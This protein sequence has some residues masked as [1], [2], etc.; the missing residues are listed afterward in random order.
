MIEL[1][2]TLVVW[3]VV[4]SLMAGQPFKNWYKEKLGQR[5]YEGTSRI[6][7]NTVS[8]ITLIPVFYLLA[9]RVPSLALWS[10]P[11][12]YNYLAYTVQL[13]GLIGLAL[14]LIQ[15]D[16]WSFLGLRQFGRFL[17]GDPQPEPPARFIS[18]GTYALVRHPLYLFSLLY[19][20][21]RP[22]MTLTNLVLNIWVTIYFLIG[23]IHE[24]RRLLR[25]F[26]EDYDAYKARVPRMLPV[27]LPV[28][29]NKPG[30]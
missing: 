20:W 9:T 14:S 13:I 12:P 21:A 30:R 27:K 28:Y 29:P 5:A 7:Y 25:E 11:S 24:E 22:E 4:H 23:S 17:R 8:A 15:T 19:L 10:I 3:A 26:G 1:L 6:F 18:G 16:I 2:L